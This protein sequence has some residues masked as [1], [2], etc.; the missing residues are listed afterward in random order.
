MDKKCL[1]MLVLF[2]CTFTVGVAQETDTVPRWDWHLSV[3]TEVGAG[4][5]RAQS[6]G[7]V[8]P[9]VTY[10][11]S[12]RL[13][14][15]GGMLVA[16]S[17]LPQGYALQGRRPMSRAPRREGTR[18]GAVWAKVDYKV[19]DALW[20]WASVM[21]A[22]GEVQPLWLDGSAPLGLTAVSGGLGYEFPNGSLM[23]LHFHLVRDH[24]GTA[25]A[26][27]PPYPYYG[28]LAPGSGLYGGPWSW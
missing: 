21:H 3:G 19:S 13:T 22:G 27:L 2:L 26:V 17:L 8:A 10:R 6:L 7:W 28:M 1:I 14:V 25:P 11:A 5:G 12:D 23:E 15:D 9:S 20:I 18:A 24:Y 4:F 16:G